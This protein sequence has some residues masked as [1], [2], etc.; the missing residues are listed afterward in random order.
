MISTC[1][2]SEN[3]NNI[4]LSDYTYPD[5]INIVTSQADYL[6][7]DTSIVNDPVRIFKSNSDMESQQKWIITAQNISDPLTTYTIKNFKTGNVLTIEEESL[8]SRVNIVATPYTGMINQLWYISTFYD[9]GNNYYYFLSAY[10]SLCINVNGGDFTEGEKL[11][12]YP[13][14]EK[15]KNSYYSI[16]I[17]TI[18]GNISVDSD[19]SQ[20]TS[21]KSTSNSIGRTNIQSNESTE[22]TIEK[23]KIEAE[24]E[25]ENEVNIEPTKKT[26]ATSLWQREIIDN[27]I[28]EEGG[29]SDE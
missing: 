29:E 9:G 11:I 28:I 20:L 22:E 3:D 12:T 6:L 13:F 25:K 4:K 15:E 5:P 14:N 7:T 23:I 2:L 21:N 24:E 26:S 17:V 10:S 16:K 8:D 19:N 1:F 27:K 18:D